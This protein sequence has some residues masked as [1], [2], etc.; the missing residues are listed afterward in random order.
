MNPLWHEGTRQKYKYGEAW[1]V[2]YI[3]LP[4]T[5]NGKNYVHT[6]VEVSTGWRETYPVSHAT[7]HNTILGLEEQT[8]W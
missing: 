6:M 8:L 5:F 1:Q 2:D 7:A 3:T 4:Q